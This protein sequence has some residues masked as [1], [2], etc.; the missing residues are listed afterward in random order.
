MQDKR[1]PFD[2]AAIPRGGVGTP[3]AGPTPIVLQKGLTMAN[4]QTALSQAKQPNT[5]G[6]GTSNP[7]APTKPADKK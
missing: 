4:L 6:G 7:P 3:N 2:R 1:F 5:S